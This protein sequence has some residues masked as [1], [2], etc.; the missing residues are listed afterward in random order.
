MS[1]L[2]LA[3]IV[4]LGLASGVLI[5]CVGIGGVILVP[6]LS[7]IA[8]IPI[9]TT[10]PA[11]IAA[12]LVSGL[13]GSFAYW[14]AGSVPWAMAKPLFMG[15][16]PSAL[17]G[18]FA[19]SAAHAGTLELCIGLLTAASGYHAF[20]SQ[21]IQEDASDVGLTQLQLLSAGV[22]TGFASALTGTG[23]PLVLVPILMWLKCPVLPAVGMAQV[24]QVPIALTATAGNVS[25]GRLDLELAA[26]LAVGLAMGTWGGAK[27][28]H[29]VPR[30]SLRSMVA[31]VLVVVGSAILIKALIWNLG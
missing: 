20:R 5:G 21:P 7:Y 10:I 12:F 28:A 18:A 13:I 31:I 15:A 14:R 6:A 19:S 11:A 3:G 23:G 2:A 29:A 22:V 24:I 17:V 30:A 27:I 26:I 16:M 8:G 25:I 4:V 9:H 1:L